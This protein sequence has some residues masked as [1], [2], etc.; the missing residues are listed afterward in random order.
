MG[1]NHWR[2]AEAGSKVT[3]NWAVALW[4]G[5]GKKTSWQ[6]LW[7]GSWSARQRHRVLLGRRGDRGRSS[8][9][10][11]SRPATWRQVWGLHTCW[12]RSRRSGSTG[13]REQ[14]Y[15]LH[16]CGCTPRFRSLLLFLP[17][18]RVRQ[19]KRQQPV[20]N[21]PRKTHPRPPRTSTNTRLTQTYPRPL[22]TN[23]RDCWQRCMGQK[24]RDTTTNH[25][26]G[27]V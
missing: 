16:A 11:A 17:L 6:M 19:K 12:I 25:G 20:N 24:W 1:K 3:S 26:T 13:D 15:V 7:P 18:S 10:L 22:R 5:Q 14:R 9:F 2:G 4:M 21:Q 8:K 23:T 27:E